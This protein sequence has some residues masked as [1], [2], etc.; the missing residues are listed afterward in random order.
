MPD[1]NFGDGVSLFSYIQSRYPSTRLIALTMISNPAIIH[2]LISRGVS[3]VLSK[4]DDVE[5]II[6]AIHA[7]YAKG[8][9]LS[10]TMETIVNSGYGKLPDGEIPLS[11][12]E[13]E[14]VRLYTSGL[15]VNEIANRLKRSKQITSSQKTNAMRK[16][17]LNSD[18]D[19]LKY[20]LKA[21]KGR[22]HNQ[23]LMDYRRDERSY[24]VRGHRV[25]NLAR[26]RRNCGRCGDRSETGR[27]TLGEFGEFAPG[28]KPCCKLF[29]IE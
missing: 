9:Y 22:G 23:S 11:S 4:S 19:L 1:N 27:R 7:S 13:V 15:P 3:T 6:A 12:R 26:V 16:L 21:K 5:H 17:G 28:H 20:A 18:I 10:P 14:V 2:S 29:A 8:S 25:V 24:G